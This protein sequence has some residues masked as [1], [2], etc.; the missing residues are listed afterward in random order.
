MY[1]TGDEG[2][3]TDVKAQG[4]LIS[5]DDSRKTYSVLTTNDN[6]GYG[7]LVA[8]VTV[9]SEAKKLCLS[10]LLTMLMLHTLMVTR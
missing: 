5:K 6:S 7:S 8:D 1:Q 9:D 2:S 4:K 10:K 3:F